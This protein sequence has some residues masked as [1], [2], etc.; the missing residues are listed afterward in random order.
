MNAG[1][2]LAHEINLEDQRILEQRRERAEQA[3][4]TA[5]ATLN[6][7]AAPCDKLVYRTTV[8]AEQPEKTVSVTPPQ[9]SPQQTQIWWQWTQ[10]Q[11]AHERSEIE[12][13]LKYEI[14]VLRDAVGEALG[15]KCHDVRED[16]RREIDFVRRELEQ[17]QSK[18]NAQV[19]LKREREALRVKAADAHRAELENLCRGMREELQSELDFIKREL[20]TRVELERHAKELRD[21]IAVKG[22]AMAQGEEDALRRE[23]A[24]LREQI[25][26]QREL[27]SLRAQVAVAKAE[28]PQVPAIEARLNGEQAEL[29]RELDRQARELAKQKDRL[30]KLRVDQSMTDF[31]LKKL[32]RAQQ[33]VVELKFVTEDGQFT[34][35]DMHPDAAAAWRRFARELVAAN[36]GTMFSND[37]TGRV[38]ELPARG[39]A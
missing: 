31:S 37:P 13:E 1:D 19:E 14:E 29:K 34:M 18:F 38:I 12:G 3:Q 7:R 36:N 4:K 24:A 17:T 15:E 21:E 32:E 20:S 27:E 5:E 16:L 26:L 6:R 8:T 11:I 9:V 25:G 22:A 33:P 35:R 2:R 10:A 39:A 30:G 23:V 28:I